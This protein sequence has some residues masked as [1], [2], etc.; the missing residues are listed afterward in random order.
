MT[1]LLYLVPACACVALI[2]CAK[3]GTHSDDPDAPPGSSDAPACGELC[4]S[5]GDGVLDG[6]DACPDTPQGEPVNMEG[7]SASQ[8]EPTLNPAFPPYNLTFTETGDAGRPGGLTWSY[9]NIDRGDLFHIFWVPCD[10]P[11]DVCAL[12]M[13]GP[14]DMPAE[15][16]HYDGGQSNLASGILVYTNTMSIPLADTTVV[17]LSGRLTVT[18]VDGSQVAIPFATL[19][20]LGIHSARIGTH[21]AEIPGTAYTITLLMEVADGSGVWTPYLDYY[22]AAPTA[23]PGPGTAVSFGGFFYDD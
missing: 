11:A 15:D 23:D 13:D 12:S 9:T 20:T 10:D 19:A 6:A 5:D 22:D 1:K 2:G 18:I 21:G 7:C 17:P 16:W 3:G 14:I 8:V 4:D